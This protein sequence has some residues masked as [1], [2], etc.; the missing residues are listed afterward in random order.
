MNWTELLGY[1]AMGL[2]AF[3][4]TFRNLVTLR[5]VNIFAALIFIV[6]GLLIKALPVVGLNVI[7][8]ALNVYELYRFYYKQGQHPET[9]SS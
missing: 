7:I 2:A 9:Y 3:S 5:K 1:M 6:Y 4:F 8:L